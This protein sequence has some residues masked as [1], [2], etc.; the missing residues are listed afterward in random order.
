MLRQKLWTTF[1]KLDIF[2]DVHA[3]KLLL[4]LIVVFV[5][6]PTIAEPYWY[7]DEAIYLTVGNSLRAGERMYVDII[8]H[9][10]PLIYYIAELG[11]TQF[12]YRMIGTGAV[13]ISTVAFYLLMK[14]LFFHQKLRL[15]AV[16]I[17]ILATNLPGFEGNIP[18]GETFV[19]T[20]TLLALLAFRK[21]S[22]FQ[23]FINPSF[24]LPK[25]KVIEV[26]SQNTIL[27]FAT[28]ALMGLGTLTKVPAVFDFAL[29]FI[30]AWF[31]FVE[32][33][34][35]A[36]QNSLMISASLAHTKDVILSLIVQMGVI[37]SGW[38]VIILISIV[39]YFLRGSLQE[40]IDYGLLYNFRYA[41]SWVGAHS[42]AIYVF[43]FTLPGKVLLLA[44]WILALSV[45]KKS[46]SKAFLLGGAWMGLSLVAATLSNRPYPHYFLQVFP[47]LAVVIVALAAAVMSVISQFRRKRSLSVPIS[48]AAR[49]ILEAAGAF[50]IIATCIT[51]VHLL[52]VTP[53]PTIKYYEL[54][55]KLA[56]KQVTRDEYLGQFNMPL[57]HD[58]YR[59]SMLLQRSPD[60]EIFIWGDN[61]VLYALSGKN[62]VGRFTVAFHIDDFNAY[63]E[64]ITAIETKRPTYVIV[65]NN[66]TPLP[67][68]EEY[69]LSGYIPSLDY[70][71]MT[72]WKLTN[73]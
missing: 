55:L 69:L 5:R 46:L 73:R 44:V 49:P 58:N 33:V 52:H 15:F 6:L 47:G 27:L 45:C 13:A 70:Q 28:G 63:D 68:L 65:M 30:V 12:G 39:Y 32:S 19:M 35:Q 42:S 51:T 24:R 50:I 43:F 9:K 64:T 56:T 71:T 11:N 36:K 8:D 72:V 18:N 62:P 37:F 17:F 48:N 22:I 54:F 41:D 14:D 66:Q 16:A 1:R 60:S 20:F 25:R 67:G 21:T 3:F 38:A 10:T 29:V 26:K 53:Y 7:G 4:V 59:V 57:L 31:V 61:P 40:Y 34:T 23:S 2:L